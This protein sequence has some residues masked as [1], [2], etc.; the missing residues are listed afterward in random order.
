MRRQFFAL[1]FVAFPLAVALSATFDDKAPD[2]RAG[3][4]RRPHRPV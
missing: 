3:A 2:D 1:T 4:R